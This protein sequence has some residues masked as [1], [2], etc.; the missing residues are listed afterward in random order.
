MSHPISSGPADDPG[1]EP[2]LDTSSAAAAQPPPSAQPPLAAQPPPAQSA[3]VPAA[4]AEPPATPP[5]AEADPLRRSRASNFW[6]AIVGFG[7]LL[8]LLVIF[9]LQNRQSVEVSYL[10]LNGHMP[11]AA[12]MLISVAAGLLLAAIAGSVRILQL[13][14]RVRRTVT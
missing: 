6:V 14:R 3:P 4:P 7:I 5:P 12:A 2:Q 11:L 8:V 10:G 13:R 1:T 9:I